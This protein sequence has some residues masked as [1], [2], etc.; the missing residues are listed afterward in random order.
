MLAFL[1]KL[2]LFQKIQLGIILLLLIGLPLFYIISKS[3]QD[4]RQRA[5]GGA[6]LE[7]E[8]GQITGDTIRIIPDATSS[9][10][11]HLLFNVPTQ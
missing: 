4:I 6:S 10:G 11:K 3:Q 7:V 8:D 5:S 1:K 2:T 9:G